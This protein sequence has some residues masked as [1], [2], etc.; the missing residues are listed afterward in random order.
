MLTA[1]QNDLD[2]SRL[3][4][5]KTTGADPEGEGGG[6]EGGARPPVFASNSLRSPL[7]WPKYT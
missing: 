2:Y 7:N 1:K 3:G 6:G 4:K 5:T